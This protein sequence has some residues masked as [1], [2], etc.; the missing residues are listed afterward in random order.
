VPAQLALD[1]FTM[2]HEAE[3]VNAQLGFGGHFHIKSA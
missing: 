3:E 2:L 1:N